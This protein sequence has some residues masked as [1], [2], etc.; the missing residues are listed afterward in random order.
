MKLFV[1][2][3]LWAFELKIQM[4]DDIIS[5]CSRMVFTFYA[6]TH[7]NLI[8]DLYSSNLPYIR[9]II[10]IYSLISTLIFALK[11]SNFAKPNE[12]MR[13]NTQ[14]FI[15]EQWT[16]KVSAVWMICFEKFLQISLKMQELD[17]YESFTYGNSSINL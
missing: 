14:L 6:H 7:T 12:E 10:H 4:N 9:F 16:V 15:H 2:M 13:M 5:R 11:T 8:I 3:K 17:R 1:S